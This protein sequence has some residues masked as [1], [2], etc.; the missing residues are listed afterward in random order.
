MA[1]DTNN[2]QEELLTVKK[3]T[4]SDN[5]QYK[6]NEYVTVSY[7]EF[8]GETLFVSNNLLKVKGKN[9]RKFDSFFCRILSEGND[10]ILFAL[11]IPQGLLPDEISYESLY[12]KTGVTVYRTELVG[13]DAF[14]YK[15]A[16]FYK[17]DE[18]V[19]KS[20]CEAPY[21]RMQLREYK[22]NP[23]SLEFS[24]EELQ[25]SARMFYNGAFKMGAYTINK[26][27]TPN[28]TKR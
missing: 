6:S 13:T 15:Y 25:E 9:N 12:F 18:D 10:D 27:T 11:K 17:I 28:K 1:T 22:K 23:Q 3:K 26:K 5:S 2:E 19:L 4:V 16:L 14:D 24:N 21:V 8:V 7:D 20:L